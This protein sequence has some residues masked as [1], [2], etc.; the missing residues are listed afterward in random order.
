[1]VL[2][3]GKAVLHVDAQLSPGGTLVIVPVPPPAKTT[4]SAC[5][6]PVKQTTLTVMLPVMIAPVEEIF[7]VLLFVFRV[8]EIRLP[9]Q[10]LPVAVARPVE[11][12]VTI[13]GVFDA[14]V[15]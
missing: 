3:V 2:P 5:P 6:V 8:A 7:P 12:T 1:M 15:T 10:E 4:V 13:P 14:H 9:P 11:S